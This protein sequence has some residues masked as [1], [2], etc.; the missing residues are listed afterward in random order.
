[1]ADIL[2]TSAVVTTQ[3]IHA[4]AGMDST[5]SEDVLSDVSSGYML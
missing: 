5:A 4:L 2:S 1:M 3:N